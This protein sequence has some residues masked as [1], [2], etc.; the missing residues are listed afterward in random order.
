MWNWD[1]PADISEFP[2]VMK[3]CF[4]RQINCCVDDGEPNRLLRGRQR[5]CSAEP[6]VD[7]GIAQWSVYRDSVPEKIRA[8]FAG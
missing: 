7:D 5:L 6:P 1:Y 2:E 4:Y 8:A 3:T